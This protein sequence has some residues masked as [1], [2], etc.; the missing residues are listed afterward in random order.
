MGISYMGCYRIDH[1]KGSEDIL[2]YRGSIRVM[3]LL[4][5]RE[6]TDQ[7]LARDVKEIIRVLDL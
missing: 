3:H 6:E 4:S 1:Q 5:S 2:V 7:E